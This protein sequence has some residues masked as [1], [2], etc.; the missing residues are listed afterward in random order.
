M[1]GCVRDSLLGVRTRD[2]DIV[3]EGEVFPLAKALEKQWGNPLIMHKRFGTAS[4]GAFEN[5]LRLDIAMARTEHYSS[6]GALPMVHSSDLPED[7]VRRD[8]SINAIAVSL[9]KSTFGRIIDPCGGLND[10]KSRTIRAMHER[11]FHDDPTRIFRA[12]RY[13][14][15]YG[16]DLEFNTRRWLREAIRSSV[17]RA[18]SDDRWDREWT[19]LVEE[20]SPY[21]V[22]RELSRLG[23]LEEFGV[24][25]ETVKKSRRAFYVLS[26]AGGKKWGYNYLSAAWWLACL[27]PQRLSR[28]TEA[29]VARLVHEAPLLKNAVARLGRNPM[30]GDLAG[31]L[32]PFEWETVHYV[33]NLEENSALRKL[34]ERYVNEWCAVNLWV[35]GDDL[36][37]FGLPP[38]PRYRKL[39]DAVRE[40][41][42][43][44]TIASGRVFE[45]RY[46]KSLIA[47]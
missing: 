41:V 15:R 35:T 17:M 29:A 1:G 32:K 19:L 18:V 45:L 20:E 34:L 38:G 23:A 40:A 10:L 24:S 37:R 31:A 5:R 33:L 9:N 22:I 14:F 2:V 6:P 12:V 46:L 27:N 3:V 11:S 44:G 36:R 7:L 39:L 42:A 4:L 13:G 8:I 28:R 43:T 21:G 25:P 47:L 30:L 16:F 26:C